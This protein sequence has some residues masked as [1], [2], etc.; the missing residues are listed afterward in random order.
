MILGQ[1]CL[2]AVGNHTG[3]IK[4]KVVP[5]PQGQ[6]ILFLFPMRQEQKKSFFWSG[7]F[8]LHL[9]IPGISS[10]LS[11]SA[12]VSWRYRL[13][14]WQMQS[15]MF[16][17]FPWI[18]VFSCVFTLFHTCSP[19]WSTAPQHYPLLF[20]LHSSWKPPNQGKEDISVSVDVIAFKVDSPT[21]TS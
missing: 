3:M 19:P 21:M 13:C 15:Q 14:L 11:T 6:S 12:N 8:R 10:F 4:E 5:T 17:L 1:T 9:R 20:N 7:H 18:T 2:G 16:G